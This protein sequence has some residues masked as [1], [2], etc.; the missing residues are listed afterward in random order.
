MPR[1]ETRMKKILIATLL[2][3]LVIACIATETSTEEWTFT[4]PADDSA[5]EPTPEQSCASP[6]EQEWSPEEFPFVIYNFLACSRDQTENIIFSP[7]AVEI[8][9]AEVV[10]ELDGPDAVVIAE[11]MGFDS[12]QDFADHAQLYRQKLLERRPTDVRPNMTE[13]STSDP[14][15]YWIDEDDPEILLDALGIEFY[16]IECDDD[17]RDTCRWEAQNDRW[18]ESFLPDENLPADSANQFTQGFVLRGQW[19]LPT[20]FNLPPIY[21]FH[22]QDGSPVATPFFP[23]LTQANQSSGDTRI[24]QSRV[25]GEEVGLTAIYHSTKS[26]QEIE[27]ELSHA[28]IQDSLESLRVRP[29]F[30]SPRL[31]FPWIDLHDTIDLS[32]LF[33]LTIPVSSTTRLATVDEG[34]NSPNPIEPRINPIESDLLP[35]YGSTPPNYRFDKPFVFII[36]DYPTESILMMGRI[37][38]PLDI[39]A[40]FP[41]ST[42]IIH[43]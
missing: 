14:D 32:E 3:P 37:V 24:L 29:S 22:R 12:P 9:L 26:L 27:S 43:D 5:D 21:D 20:N 35:G 40:G 10:Q 36:Y 23:L 19:F 7:A 30:R 2:A 42:L 13:R 33:G 31:S 18:D 25:I 28:S 41:P 17:D 16:S 11:A 15:S 39:E 8:A 4:E 6:A 38:D 34:I 1:E